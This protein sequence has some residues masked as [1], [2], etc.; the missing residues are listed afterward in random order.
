MGTPFISLLTPSANHLEG[1]DRSQPPDAGH[2]PSSIP[3]TFL[4]AMAVRKAV[5]VDEQGVPLAFEMDVDDARAC[6]WV[7]YASVHRRET[8]TTESVP[9][10]TLRLVPFPHHPHPTPGGLYE[11]GRLVR[12]EGRDGE[13]A[14]QA[15]A[16]RAATEQ[17]QQPSF[18]AADRATSLHDGREA[19]VKLG[20]LAVVR[21]FRGKGIAR[22]LVQTALGWL[23]AHPGHFD[24]S[25]AA[26]GLE[27]LSSS[28]GAAGNVD[29]P[30]WS[31]LVCCHAQDAVVGVWERCGF[32][33]DEGMG[34][35]TEEGI[36]HVGMFLRLDVEVMID[37]PLQLSRPDHFS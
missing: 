1:Y 35:W 29:V 24:P 13:A 23:R 2:Q 11:D 14:G 22:L 20:R 12:V 34:R 10:G 19:Y 16:T 8:G 9:I 21:E 17:Q 37:R 31:G 26:L 5:Y 25:V 7:V 18:G 30:R 4:D 28:A 27:Q 15:E 36:P 6:H 3:R 33:V 32:V